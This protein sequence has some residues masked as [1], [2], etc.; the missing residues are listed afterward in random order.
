MGNSISNVETTSIDKINGIDVE[1][2]DLSNI[3]KFQLKAIKQMY[4]RICIIEKEKST[5]MI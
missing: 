4:E 1:Q 5:K 2:L 3:D